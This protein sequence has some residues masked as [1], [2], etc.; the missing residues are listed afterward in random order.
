MGMRGYRKHE[1]VEI[2]PEHPTLLRELLNFHF[3]RLQHDV[4]GLAKI[5]R[6]SESDLIDEYLRNVGF[7]NEIGGLRLRLVN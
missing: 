3:E 4:Q 2:P 6:L 5:M 7:K 1:P